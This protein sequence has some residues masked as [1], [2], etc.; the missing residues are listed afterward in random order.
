ME[1][2]GQLPSLP[3]PPLKS[4]PGRIL[5]VPD[6]PGGTIGGVHPAVPRSRRA[7][8]G[9]ILEVQVD[10]VSRGYRRYLTGPGHRRHLVNRAR[11]TRSQTNWDRSSSEFYLHNNTTVFIPKKVKAAHTR[12][13]SARFR[14]W[15]RF[16]AVSLQ[17]MWGINPAVGCHY[18]PPGLQLPPQPFSLLGEQRHDGCE[19]FA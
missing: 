19:H 1:A 12:L 7:A 11:P 3:P 15:S 2:P 10:Q 17:V 13:P 16:L 18:F 5:L 9:T 14:S 6:R 8:A 4:G